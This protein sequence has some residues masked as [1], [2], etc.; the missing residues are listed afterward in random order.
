MLGFVKAD[1]AKALVGKISND[2]KTTILGVVAAALLAT[3][4][5]WG[6]LLKGDSAQVGTAVGVVITALL[7]YYTNKKDSK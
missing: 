7:G 4:L 3:K 6:L 5:D 1:F 2:N